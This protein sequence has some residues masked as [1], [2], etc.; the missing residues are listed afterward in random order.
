MHWNQQA[1]INALH[2]ATGNYFIFQ[3]LAFSNAFNLTHNF[4]PIKEANAELP[5]TYMGP[6]HRKRS[7]TEK[8]Q[9]N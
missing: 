3:A 1:L 6:Q 9:V 7:K 4:F 8:K 2:E 5:L